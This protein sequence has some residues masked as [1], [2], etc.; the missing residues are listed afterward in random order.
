MK[1]F[2]Y[3]STL[4]VNM[5]FDQ[6]PPQ[7]NKRIAAELKIDLGV[8]STTVKTLTDSDT[9]ISKLQLVLKHLEQINELGNVW[10]PKQYFSGTM[11]MN[12]GTIIFPR[13]WE[14]PVKDMVRFGGIIDNL[15]VCLVGSNS[16]MLGETGKPVHASY[17][18]PDFVRKIAND[19][20]DA[21]FNEEAPPS[22][23]AND[24]LAD[25][26]RGIDDTQYV[27][28]VAKTY[29]VEDKIHAGIRLGSPLFVAEAKKD[30][31]KAIF[32]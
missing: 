18:R 9:T 17:S 3:I 32:S 12:W 28:F 19:I 1:Y 11:N 27:E 13:E 31:G 29:F 4:K 15:R 14:S 25:I 21:S 10:T 8:F 22:F 26:N 6:I 30:T 5:L 20:R 7:L 23:I 24:L 16:H 2:I